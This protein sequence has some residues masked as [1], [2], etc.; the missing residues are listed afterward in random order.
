[1][2]FA[3]NASSGLGLNVYGWLALDIFGKCQGRAF[4]V[5]MVGSLFLD[6]RV[7]PY[8]E[9]SRMGGFWVMA[10]VKALSL[11]ALSSFVLLL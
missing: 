1:M 7:A 8:M 4:E 11:L 9:E 2:K 3:W 5:C 6:H 10:G